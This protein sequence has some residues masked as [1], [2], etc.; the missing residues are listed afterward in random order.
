MVQEVRKMHPKQSRGRLWLP[1]IF[2]IGLPIDESPRLFIN[3]DK[4]RHMLKWLGRI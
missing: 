2:S 3:P 1:L 4:D